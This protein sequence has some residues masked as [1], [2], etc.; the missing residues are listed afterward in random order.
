MTKLRTSL[1]NYLDSVKKMI[2]YQNE[3]VKEAA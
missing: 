1:A 2:D 3:L